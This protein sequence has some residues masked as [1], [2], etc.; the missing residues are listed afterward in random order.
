M[1]KKKEKVPELGD[2]IVSLMYLVVA[3]FL[4]LYSLSG[5]KFI[6]SCLTNITSTES[7]R[8]DISQSNVVFILAIFLIAWLTWRLKK[9]G[10]I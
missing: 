2:I 3:I 1:G 4:I 9:S 7:C 10:L 5:A 8:Y 6:I